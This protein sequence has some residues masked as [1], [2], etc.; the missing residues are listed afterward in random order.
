MKVEVGRENSL[1][2]IESSIEFFNGEIVLVAQKNYDIDFPLLSDIYKVGT[3]CKVRVLQRHKDDSLTVEIEGVQRVRIMNTRLNRYEHKGNSMVTWITDYEFLKQKNE[4]V[5]ELSFKIDELLDHIEHYFKLN[6]REISLLKKMFTGEEEFKELEKCYE[7][8]TE[9]EREQIEG[10]IT[11]KV[12]SNISRQQRE[13][14]LRERIKVIREEF[15]KDQKNISKVKEELNKNHWKTSLAQSI[16]KGLGREC[17]KISLGGVSDEAEIR[18]HRKTYIGSMPGKI[19]KGLRQAGVNNPV[20][21]LDEVDK[22]T[23]GHGDP[24]AAL[25]EVLDPKQNYAFIDNYIEESVDLSKAMFIAT[26]NYEENIPEPLIDR[27]EV[28]RLSSY[29]EREKFEIAKGSLI[30]EV[31]REHGLKEDELKISDSAILYIIRRYT[32]EA[33]VRNLKQM[34]AQIARKFVQKQEMDST[35]AEETVNEELVR[36]YLSI[37]RY[38]HTVKDELSIPGIVNGM[39]YTEYGGDLLPVEINYFSGKGNLNLTGNLKDTMKE[40]ASVA[41]SY[42]RANEKEFNLTKIK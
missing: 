22:L 4:R 36:E 1:A 3:F 13:F 10:Q 18:G 23:S 15:S 2:A 31:L 29:T 21:I 27:L 6:R 30:S 9:E 35:V 24:V 37:E 39:A 7:V 11:K 28:I 8:L 19:V 12:N 41:L 42:I 40:S 5:E 14:Y 25:L 33:G 32:R 26:A 38:D 17:V 16:A 34:I 20:F